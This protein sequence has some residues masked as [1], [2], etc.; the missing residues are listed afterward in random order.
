MDA[1]NL[2]R[3]PGA[4]AYRWS[5]AGMGGMAMLLFL[6][7]GTFAVAPWWVTALFLVV[8]IALF[9]IACRWFIRHPPRLP[10]LPLAGFVVWL[11][12]IVSGVHALGWRWG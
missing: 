8:W 9:V 1:P 2:P 4:R 3:G 11:G 12:T 5:F 6:D 10:V 7:L